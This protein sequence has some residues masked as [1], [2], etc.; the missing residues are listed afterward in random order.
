MD[1]I[2]FG[3]FVAQLRKERA[4]TQKELA[5]RLHVTDKAVSKWETGKGF[6][7][8]KLLEPLA[9]ALE[10]SLV[11]LLQG[12][13]SPSPTL[14]KEEAGQ[15]AVRAMER[16]Q[17]STARRYLKL[18]RWLLT[19]IGVWCLLSSLP[20]LAI[21]FPFTLGYEPAGVEGVIGGADGPTA[22]LIGTADPMFPPQVY[23]AVQL[24]A[25]AACVVLAVRVRKVERRL[26]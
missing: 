19:A 2:Q 18:L 7:D 6:P 12:E 13:R 16:S 25:L 5:D 3:A 8:L 9:E 11:E 21:L 10:V 14:T 23:L 24:I 26:K 1:N 15:A 20:L 17:Q 22:V 4:L